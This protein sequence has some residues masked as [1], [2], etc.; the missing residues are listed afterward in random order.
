MLLPQPVVLYQSVEKGVPGT[1]EGVLVSCKLTGG[2]CPDHS[3]VEEML[4]DQLFID[5]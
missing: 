4:L 1:K 3:S 5:C 2:C